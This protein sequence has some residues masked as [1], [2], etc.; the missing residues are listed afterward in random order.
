MNQS[1]LLGAGN[2]FDLGL[3]TMAP[4]L[5]VAVASVAAWKFWQ[6]NRDDQG[7]ANQPE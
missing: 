7:G 1:Y 6:R 2:A 5:L 4:I 3:L